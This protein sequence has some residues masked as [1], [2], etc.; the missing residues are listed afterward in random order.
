MVLEIA[1]FLISSE[2]IL[3]FTIHTLRGEIFMDNLLF[4]KKQVVIV[5]VFLI[6]ISL[7]LQVVAVENYGAEGTVDKEEFTLE[8]MLTFALEDEFLARAEYEMIINEFGNQRPFSNIIKAEE[9]HIE[10]LKPLFEDNGFKFPEDRSS[11]HLIMPQNITEALETGVR[12]EIANIDMYEKFLEQ[13][14]SDEVRSVFE[15][16]KRGSENHLRAF[17]NGLSRNDGIGKGYLN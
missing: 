3:K 9:F 10:L 7:S 8:E 11:E 2:Q 4:G 14:L 5:L 12:A 1:K 6:L 13:D 17:K 15:E 16:L